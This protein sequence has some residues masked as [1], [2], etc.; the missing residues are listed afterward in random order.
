MLNC[1]DPV[2]SQTSEYALRA[3]VW[4]AGQSLNDFHFCNVNKIAEATR[5]PHSYLSKILQTLTR[6]FL[7][8]K[9]RGIKGGYC[10]R[11]PPE[12]IT[13]LSIVENFDKI[14]R[15][16]TC[17]LKLK[18][19]AERLCPL[20]S[21]LDKLACSLRGNFTKTTLKDLINLPADALCKL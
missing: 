1:G 14:E 5:V 7:L 3:M 6:A 16:L 18:E 8:Q 21:E 15:I 10:L 12:Q 20:H 9:K 13:L 17:P 19:H 11:S 2:L 4:L